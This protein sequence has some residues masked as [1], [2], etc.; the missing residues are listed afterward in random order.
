[1]TK[2]DDLQFGEWELPS[3]AGPSG[4]AAPCKNQCQHVAANTPECQGR[5]L[6]WTAA[7]AQE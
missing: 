2:G 1:M 3:A 6:A 7:A 5:V 4:G